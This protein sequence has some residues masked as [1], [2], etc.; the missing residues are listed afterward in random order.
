L[1]YTASI[2]DFACAACAA[3]AAETAIAAIA[4]PATAPIGC[5]AIA[6]VLEEAAKVA[7]KAIQEDKS[8][9]EVAAAVLALK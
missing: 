3:A 1:G 2:Y 4:T 9:S 5:A 8:G 7:W 6:I